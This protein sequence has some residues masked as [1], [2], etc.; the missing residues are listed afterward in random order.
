[1][2]PKY[3]L[4]GPFRGHMSIKSSSFSPSSSCKL[5][6]QYIIQDHM[7]THYRKLLSAKAAVDSSAPKSLN[8]SI[9]YQDQQK[10]EM[11]I[12]AVEKYKKEMSRIPSGPL[13]HPRSVSTEN[14]KWLQNSPTYT[15]SGRMRSL[16]KTEPHSPP[17]FKK[18]LSSSHS[19]VLRA[20]EAIHDIVQWS[21]SQT[22]N[23]GRSI[24]PQGPLSPTKSR[25]PVL[26]HT[27]REKL[28]IR[29][30]N[31]FAA[32]LLDR[33]AQWFTETVQPFTPRVLKTASK[34]YLSKYRYYNGPHGKK[35]PSLHQQ[36]FKRPNKFNRSSEDECLRSYGDYSVRH[37]VKKHPHNSISLHS[38]LLAK[39]EEL[40]YLQFLQELAADILRRSCYR[41]EAVSDVFQ[42]HTRK[43]RYDLDEV[44]MRRIFQALKDD[45]N[46]CP[47]LPDSPVCY[48]CLKHRRS[49]LNT[50][51]TF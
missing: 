22:Q 48:T 4:M 37:P 31:F 36:P 26:S 49:C 47:H 44:K 12:K 5:S 33:H 13:C 45:L 7:S 38:L 50:A 24:F 21:L 10:R 32:D 1:M 40:K 3:S 18:M 16:K 23:S 43:R 27:R 17:C 30:K 34:P 14:C 19:P 11:L 39:E 35:S 6:S 15:S 9:K 46:I 28:Q 2:I 20:E 41:K 29:Q 8:T 25:M 42:M 51:T